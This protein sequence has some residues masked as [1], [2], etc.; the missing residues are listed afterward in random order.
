MSES[1][2]KH[3]K[4]LVGLCVGIFLTI[5]SAGLLLTSV[6]LYCWAI[7]HGGGR[8]VLAAIQGTMGISFGAPGIWVGMRFVRRAR[9][10]YG[11]SQSKSNNT[12]S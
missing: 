6:S 11:R 3:G 7:S 9:L 8:G 10:A 5:V 1:K 12:T 4:A 2:G